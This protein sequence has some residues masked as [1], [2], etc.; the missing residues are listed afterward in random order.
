MARSTETKPDSTIGPICLAIGRCDAIPSGSMPDQAVA[1]RIWVVCQPR[2]VTKVAAAVLCFDSEARGHPRKRLPPPLTV[3]HSI[4]TVPTL[5]PPPAPASHADGRRGPAVPP[6]PDIAP[7]RDEDLSPRA[8]ADCS[9]AGDRAGRAARL[10]PLADEG[11]VQAEL[12]DPRDRGVV[13]IE[14]SGWAHPKSNQRAADPA[15]PRWLGT[16]PESSLARALLTGCFRRA[17]LPQLRAWSTKPR[18]PR[19]RPG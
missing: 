1:A 14:C 2:C 12:L 9:R 3:G 5:H 10:P 4:S 7:I 17:R 16:A 11:A 15:H 13:E 6:N 18:S 8:D 19:G